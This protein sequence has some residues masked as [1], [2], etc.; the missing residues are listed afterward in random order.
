V[1][2]D[3]GIIWQYSGV[4]HEVHLR[5]QFQCYMVPPSVPQ[6]SQKASTEYA[7]TCMCSF[8]CF[9]LDITTRSRP[10]PFVGIRALFSLILWNTFQRSCNLISQHDVPVYLHLDDRPRY[11][12]GHT[13]LR[14][15]TR[16][17]MLA[18]STRVAAAQR[19]ARRPITPDHTLGSALLQEL[20]LL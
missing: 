7:L 19:N 1:Q 15:Y 8:L 9:E 6:D 14:L 2:G 17:E 20:D 10:L 13:K 5:N 4:E 18:K 16:Q 3:K 11:R 12:C